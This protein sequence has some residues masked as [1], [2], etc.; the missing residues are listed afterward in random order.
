MKSAL[1]GSYIS[2]RKIGF[3][4]L[5]TALAL[6]I[7]LSGG[8]Y[9]QA[10][11]TGSKSS[12][13]ATNPR[14]PPIVPLF[15]LPGHDGQAPPP[16]SP[17]VGERPTGTNN[18]SVIRIQSDKTCATH[19]WENLDWS[20]STLYQ[21]SSQR[22]RIG[23]GTFDSNSA[24]IDLSVRYNDRPYT[25]ADVS[26]SYSH[27]SGSVPTGPNVTADQYAGFLR[28]LQPL[29]PAWCPHWKPADLETEKKLNHQL[30]ILAGVGYGGSPGSLTLPNSPVVY[31]TSHTVFG[32]ALLDYQFA[33]FPCR[34]AEARDP[35]R[36]YPSLL[37]ELSS[38]VQCATVCA[39]S[40]S[41]GV[42]TTSSARQVD[43]LNIASLTYSF[44]C[45][46]G[47]QVAIAWDSP[48][49]SQPLRGA[50]PD[51]ANTATFSG[52][53]VYNAYP[54]KSG[55]SCNRDKAVSW[56]D[57]LRDSNRWSGSVLYSYTAFDPLTETNTL[58]VQISYSF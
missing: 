40:S 11:G 31:N 19:W 32:D 48:L 13:K 46:F 4:G 8:L 21:F 43:Y 25:S 34:P 47:V 28:V 15:K 38:G 29:N 51:R 7:Y 3:V 14:P 20:L 39:N 1:L 2:K 30:A 6:G 50:K 22:S 53:L 35:R 5:S 33:W 41:A 44:P 52:G 24:I 57:C 36:L 55:P 37:F 42:T 56:W 12:P 18:K 17:T 54:S 9:A 10:T 58:Q 49:D 26:F 16:P 45:R 23:D 27:V